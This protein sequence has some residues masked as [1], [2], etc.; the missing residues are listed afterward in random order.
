MSTSAQVSTAIAAIFATSPLLAITDKAH[1][2]LV[3][4]LSEFELARVS[5]SQQIRFFEYLVGRT[6]QFRG[7]SQAA[8]WVYSLQVNFI[9]ERGTDETNFL[10][11]RDAIDTFQEGMLSTTGSD[12][13]GTVNYYQPQSAAPTITSLLIGDIDCHRFSWQVNGFKRVSL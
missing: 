8:E 9:I 1:P 11:G 4:E 5:Y 2:Y 3:T 10:I 13:S 12:W 7:T 6:L